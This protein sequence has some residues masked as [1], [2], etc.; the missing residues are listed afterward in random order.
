MF[1]PI[2]L[3]YVS[4]VLDVWIMIADFV[5]LSRR[6]VLFFFFQAEDGIR[7]GTVTGVQTC[8]LPISLRKLVRKLGLDGSV[9]LAGAQPNPW[10]IMSQC[11]AFVLS[12]DYEG[13][14]MVILEDR[15][16]VV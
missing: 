15:K 14:P 7:D 10:A 6:C 8:A 3:R 5:L 16:S 12:S 4:Q 9:V 1:D 2:E 11:D 13:Q